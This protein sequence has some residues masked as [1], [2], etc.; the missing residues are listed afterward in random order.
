MKQ[1]L[2][3]IQRVL[4][5]LIVIFAGK[6][7]SLSH[8]LLF[9]LNFRAEISQSKKISLCSNSFIYFLESNPYRT[10]EEF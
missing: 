10:Q 5:L 2:G 3:K 6:A 9:I 7:S 1:I 8:N 4:T